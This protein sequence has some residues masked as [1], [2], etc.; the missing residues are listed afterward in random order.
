VKKLGHPTDLF[1]RN[2]VDDKLF[3]SKTEYTDRVGTMS[4]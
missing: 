2:T 3:Q 4:N 1:I